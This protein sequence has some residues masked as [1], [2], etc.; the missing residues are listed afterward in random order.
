[1]SLLLEICMSLAML[2]IAVYTGVLAVIALMAHK[3]KVELTKGT[4][5]KFPPYM[6]GEDLI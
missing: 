3:A 2:G 4:E 5:E 1:M 6:T